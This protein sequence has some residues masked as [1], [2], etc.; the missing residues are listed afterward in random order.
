MALTPEDVSNKRF[1][2]VR[3]RE[4]YDMG[5]VDRF[6]DEVESELARLIA[7]S[8][9][10]RTKIGAVTGLEDGAA[11]AA[12]TAATTVSTTA[13]ASA[14]AT[15]LLEIAGRNADELVD[16][17]R[18]DAERIL[19]DARERA[20]QVDEETNERR[21]RALTELNNERSGLA[22]EIERLRRF[23]REYRDQLRAYFEDQLAALEGQGGGGVLLGREDAEDRPAEQVDD[24]D[25]QPGAT[26]ES[27]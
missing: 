1:S 7:E 8:T 19:H 15:R 26:P 24:G 25:G 22:A 17:A 10:L 23:E 5:E 13:E 11:A 21:D 18:A 2:T 14:A 3:L 4:G 20:G 12:A 16:E 27:G 6:L 9:E